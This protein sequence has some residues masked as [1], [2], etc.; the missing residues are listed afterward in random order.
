MLFATHTSTSEAKV[1]KSPPKK[2]TE[3]MDVLKNELKKCKLEV[4]RVFVTKQDI[5]SASKLRKSWPKT[6]MREKQLCKYLLDCDWLTAFNCN[7]IGWKQWTGTVGKLQK[8]LYKR[9]FRVG[10]LVGKRRKTY[11][12]PCIVT[13]F[14]APQDDYTGWLHTREAR[15]GVQASSIII[16]DN[17]KRKDTER[18]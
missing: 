4:R 8:T 18:L 2:A 1:R 11:H 5:A 7:L 3:K 17:I 6:D 9:W 10:W 14:D 16:N 12:V 15:A 13:L